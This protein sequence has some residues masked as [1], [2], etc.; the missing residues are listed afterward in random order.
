MNSP[1]KKEEVALLNV[2]EFEEIGTNIAETILDYYQLRKVA[3]YFGSKLKNSFGFQLSLAVNILRM[4]PFRFNND[5]RKII[6]SINS[7]QLLN[8]NLCKISE[9]IGL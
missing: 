3:P 2:K 8:D 5:C 9:K 7:G 6:N 4:I 1:E